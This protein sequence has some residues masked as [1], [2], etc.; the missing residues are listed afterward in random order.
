MVQEGD[1]APEIPSVGI[2]STTMLVAKFLVHGVAS[3][4]MSMQVGQIDALA[5]SAGSAPW[6]Q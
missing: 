5:G 4:A 2:G 1:W 3:H 6:D